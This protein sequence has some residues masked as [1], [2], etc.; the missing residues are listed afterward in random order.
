MC[1]CM[2]KKS[3]VW[4]CVLVVLAHEDEIVSPAAQDQPGQHSET[5]SLKKKEKENIIRI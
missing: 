2:C 3:Q 1:M 5:C 4:C